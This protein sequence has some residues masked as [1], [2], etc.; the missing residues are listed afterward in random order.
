MKEPLFRMVQ[1]EVVG[2][3]IE[4]N[5]KFTYNKKGKYVISITYESV[6]GE[7][8]VVRSDSFVPLTKK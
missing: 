4:Q 6:Y 2:Q 3:F 7:V 8:W 5:F 1:K